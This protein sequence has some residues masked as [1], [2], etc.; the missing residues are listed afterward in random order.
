MYTIDDWIM[1]KL[2][3]FSQVFEVKAPVSENLLDW[4]GCALQELKA[5]DIQF[6]Y[7]AFK[8]AMQFELADYFPDMLEMIEGHMREFDFDVRNSFPLPFGVF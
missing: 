3:K 2:I 6:V 5:T 1:K 8:A 4:W 7:L